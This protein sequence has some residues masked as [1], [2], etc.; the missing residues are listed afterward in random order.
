MELNTQL[1][2][3]CKKG[4]DL[5]RVQYLVSEGADITCSERYGRGLSP[6]MMA[7]RDN[8]QTI[9]DWILNT[10]SG[11]SRLW[12]MVTSY[13]AIPLHMACISS[14]SDTVTR[15]ARLTRDVNTRNSTG[16]TPIAVA[17]DY[18]NLPGVQAM[19]TVPGVDLDTRNNSGQSLEDKAR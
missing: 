14:D 11:D 10:Y 18:N 6:V 8:N 17:V 19:L 3:E 12:N 9:S 2:D 16:H 13:G 4:G 15:V 5:G 7:L 1:L